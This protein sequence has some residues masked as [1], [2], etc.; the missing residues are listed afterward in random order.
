MGGDAGTFAAKQDNKNVD[1]NQKWQP[2]LSLVPIGWIVLLDMVEI[3]VMPRMRTIHPSLA[4]APEYL[5]KP[6]TSAFLP[7]AGVRSAVNL[8][9]HGLN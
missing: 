9:G 3:C 7:H 6:P 5:P 2:R 8:L 4:G 1:E